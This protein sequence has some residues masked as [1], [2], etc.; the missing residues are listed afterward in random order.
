MGFNFRGLAFKQS[1]MILVAVT[2][3]VGLIFGI[4][5]S[6][7]SSQLEEMTIE[8]GEQ[9]SLANVTYI[10]KLF[11]AGK[12]VGE[13]AASTLSNSRMTK[14]ELDE[15]LTHTL[16]T[17]RNLVP[18]IVAVVATLYILKEPSLALCRPKVHA[19]IAMAQAKLSKTA[20]K[21]VE[22]AVTTAS[23]KTLMSI[24]QLVST[25]A[26]RSVSKARAKEAS[27]AEKMATYT[28]KFAS[29]KTQ[30]SP[31]MAMTSTWNLSYPSS[32]VPSARA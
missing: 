10:D 16:A 18:H 29:R 30:H 11:D 4:M 27:M 3:I 8:N 9:I 17:A 6:K 14:A 24:S 20:A 25:M 5:T 21:P 7:M 2:V 31:V 26:S 22:A 19:N 12:H 23:I 13:D 28:S 1:L 32:T 15:F